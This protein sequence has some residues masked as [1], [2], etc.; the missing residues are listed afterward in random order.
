MGRTTLETSTLE[1]ASLESNTNKKASSMSKTICFESKST[2]ELTLPGLQAC[3]RKGPE[4]AFGL[5]DITLLGA[6][7]RIEVAFDSR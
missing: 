3:A 7:I 4:A 6:A 1:S 5:L 2:S